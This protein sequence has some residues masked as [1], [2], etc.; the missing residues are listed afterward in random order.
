MPAASAARQEARAAAAAVAFLTTLPVGKLLHAGGSDLARAGPAFPIVG[1]ALG[2]CVGG[3]ALGLAQACPPL[4]AAGAALALGTVLT[5]AMHLD[6]LADTADALGGRS[7]HEAL[8]IMRD[9]NTGSFG[10]AAV[11]LCLLVEAGALAELADERMLGAVVAAYAQSRAIAPPLAC[12]LP[13]ARPEGGLGQS[14]VDGRRGRAAATVVIA[15]AV[16]VAAVPSYA[17]WLLLATAVTG[18]LA[19]AGSRR[20]FGGVTGDT[21]GASI[22]AAQTVCLVVVVS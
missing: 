22:A 19:F 20:R 3:V 17:P 5:G 1:A 16:S 2:L 14:V 7:R 9:P 15:V 12:L 21:L 4:V 11:V 6:A 18:A 8:E 13:Y 10:T